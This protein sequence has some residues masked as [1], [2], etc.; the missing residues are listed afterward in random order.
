MK[1]SQ[2]KQSE[3]LLLLQKN[4][5]MNMPDKSIL[6]NISRSSETK[7]IVENY[8]YIKDSGK[9]WISSNTRILLN[10]QNILSLITKFK[11]S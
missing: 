7:N 9:N 1:R 4:F 11:K 8:P 5:G 3:N 10:W 6:L 2:K